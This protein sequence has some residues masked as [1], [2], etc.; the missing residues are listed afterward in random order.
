MGQKSKI[1]SIQPLTHDVW[2]LVVEKPENLDYV[3]GQAVDIAI[4]KPGWENEIRPF[5][6]TSLPEEETIEFVIKSYPDNKGVTAQ[7]PNLKP[8]DNLL[9]GDVFGDIHYKGPGVFIAGG[10]G[11][12]PFIAIFKWLHQR[13]EAAANKLL[14]ANKT[15]SDII[16]RDWFERLLGENFINI[17]SDEKAEG[18]LNGHITPDLLAE[19]K[20]EGLAHYYL[21]GPPPMM[22]AVKE[23]LESIGIPESA[24]VK[25]DFA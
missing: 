9:V 17:L 1:L 10:A 25:E 4:D 5:T 18:C 21:C 11:I 20:N 23:S 13:G 8:D 15:Q 3:A 24:V 16:L 6:F 19:Q 7:I 14:F 2:H 12:T 22:K